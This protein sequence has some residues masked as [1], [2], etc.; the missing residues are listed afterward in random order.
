MHTVRLP[1]GLADQPAACSLLGVIC[2]HN[3]AH[4]LIRSDP[5]PWEPEL[6][7]VIS[8]ELQAMAVLSGKKGTVPRL[9]LLLQMCREAYVGLG[10]S[11][12]VLV[13]DG[14]R[15]RILG[16]VRSLCLSEE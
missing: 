10:P 15:Y 11:D 8:S 6:S 2:K 4:A 9:L 1:A 5:Q 13:Y 7:L 3:T 14:R 16:L 12:C